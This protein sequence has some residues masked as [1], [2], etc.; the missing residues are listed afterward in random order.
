MGFLSF[1]LDELE[2]FPSSGS[3]LPVEVDSGVF[4]SFNSVELPGGGNN[5]LTG[6]S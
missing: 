6:G 2:V 4:I 5:G 3:L 1:L